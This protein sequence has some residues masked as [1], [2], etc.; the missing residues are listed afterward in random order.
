MKKFLSVV[1]LTNCLIASAFAQTAAVPAP[2]AAS[3]ASASASVNCTDGKV[4][5]STATGNGMHVTASCGNA[6]NTSASKSKHVASKKSAEKSVVS[7]T[8]VDQSETVRRL[9]HENANLKA[10]TSMNSASNAGYTIAGVGPKVFA[11]EGKVYSD[12]E[13]NTFERHTGGSRLCRFMVNGQIRKELFVQHPDPKES[14]KQCDLLAQEFIA[15]MEPTTP[16]MPTV[17]VTTVA[18]KTNVATVAPAPSE[19]SFKGN[20][21]CELKFD[22][23]VVETTTTAND[24]ECKVWT[25]NQA[26]R[27]GWIPKNSL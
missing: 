15:S 21:T 26:Q 25:K 4:A 2:A 10:K 22:G 9:A 23:K 20:H 5:K 14:K 18:V 12:A 17:A 24:D 11:D 19:T 6:T 16:A 13:G 7:T 8:H 3:T 27:R 1:I